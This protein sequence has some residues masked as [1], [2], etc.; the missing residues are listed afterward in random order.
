MAS[1]KLIKEL[2][3]KTGAGMLDCREALQETSGDLDK[4][5]VFLR[6]KGLKDI[7]DR[8]SKTAA[9]GKIG[10]Y[11][12]AG[13]QIAVLV[14]V[15]CETDFS[16]NSDAFQTFSHDLAMHIAATSPKWLTRDEVPEETIEREK[17]VMSFNIK[18]K[19]PEIVEKIV[20]GRLDKFFRDNCLME[21]VWVKDPNLTISDLVGELGSKIN[22][23]IVIK[24]FIRYGLGEEV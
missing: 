21:Q 7:G 18:G 4:A 16:A 12:H 24:R 11:V 2:R 3:E 10:C 8:S 6:K 22:E 19:P 20:S 15:N 1:L 5:V 13:S 14:E 17:S 23:K 9:E